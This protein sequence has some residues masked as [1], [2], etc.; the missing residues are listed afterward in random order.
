MQ[1][2]KRLYWFLRKFWSPE[3]DPT[4][5]PPRFPSV[6]VRTRGSV[7]ATKV[8]CEGHI[9]KHQVRGAGGISWSA[10]CHSVHTAEHQPKHPKPGTGVS[11]WLLNTPAT[12]KPT[13]CCQ[14][15]LTAKL[16]GDHVRLI[17]ICG[18]NFVYTVYNIY[19]FFVGILWL[20][21]KHT[22]LQ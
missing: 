7:P 5:S 10:I 9:L 22:I 11:V 20:A 16:W 6:W 14:K 21:E 12:P 2:I 3:L 4:R 17:G 1:D 8:F 13:H 19:I 15:L 18:S